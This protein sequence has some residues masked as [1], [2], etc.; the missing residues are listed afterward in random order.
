MSRVPHPHARTRSL[1]KNRIVNERSE[2]RYS[3]YERNDRIPPRV[4]GATSHKIAGRRVRRENTMRFCR[5]WGRRGFLYRLRATDRPPLN[6]RGAYTYGIPRGNVSRVDAR[7]T[8]GPGRWKATCQTVTR[9][10]VFTRALLPISSGR[11][12]REQPFALSPSEPFT[13]RLFHSAL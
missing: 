1:P 8:G 12:D 2:I 6:K 10:H 5:I 7:T 9:V 3:R 11:S 4:V 13:P